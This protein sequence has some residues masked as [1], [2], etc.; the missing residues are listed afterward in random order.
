MRTFAFFLFKQVV[1]VCRLEN[2][3][4][5]SFFFLRKIVFLTVQVAEDQQAMLLRKL[6]LATLKKHLEKLWVATAEWP[7]IE[8]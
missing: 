8:W 2:I 6:I 4:F 5:F 3:K 7:E 1:L